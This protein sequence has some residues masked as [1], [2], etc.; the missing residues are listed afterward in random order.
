MITFLAFGDSGKDT[1][2]RRHNLMMMHHWKDQ[3][4]VDAVFLLG[5]NFYDYGVRS[6]NDP[7]WYD[8]ESSY[9]PWCPFYAIPGNHDYLGDIQAQ[10][11][12]SSTHNTLW[13]MPSRYYD[14]KFY[15][16]DGCGVHVFFLDTFTICPN[17]SRLCSIAMGMMDFD[18]LFSHKDVAQ[19]QWLEQ[20]L[21]ES[22]MTWKVVVGHYPVFSNGLHGNTQELVDDLYPLLQR[23]DVDFYLSG[24]DHDMEFMRKNDINFIV[25][26]TGCSSNPISYSHQSIYASDMS[27]FGFNVLQFTKQ[28]AK[29]GFATN[30]GTQ[31][32]YSVPKYKNVSYH[33]NG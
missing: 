21:A 10:V 5:D 11:Q 22:T 18:L 25:S 31:M 4:H 29:F 15:S 8:F 1:P 6:T 14:K 27:T 7:Q 12:Y 2:L 24:H 33:K 30:N 23:Y 16:Q 9:K 19:Y 17:E 20:K 26:G 32:W 3:N 13:R 28:Y